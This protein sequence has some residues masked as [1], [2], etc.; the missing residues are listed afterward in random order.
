MYKVLKFKKCIPK[1]VKTLMFL[2]FG[3]ETPSGF[4]LSRADKPSRTSLLRYMAFT[5]FPKLQPHEYT[6]MRNTSLNNQGPFYV[7]TD[8]NQEQGLVFVDRSPH[9]SDKYQEFTDPT[10][11][12]I[13][14]VVQHFCRMQK[15]PVKREAETPH[16][17]RRKEAQ[18]PGLANLPKEIKEE[19]AYQFMDPEDIAS[20]RKTNPEIRKEIDPDAYLQYRLKH[21]DPQSKS[22]LI[23]II[24]AATEVQSLSLDQI[25]KL[26][27]I[28]EKFSEEEK[29][30]LTPLDFQ[31]TWISH[32]RT[33]YSDEERCEH[34]A[35]L[36]LQLYVTFGIHE[37]RAKLQAGLSGPLE[38][39][40][41]SLV[42]TE[43][44][45]LEKN[46]EGNSE[47]LGAVV[48]FMTLNISTV[49]IYFFLSDLREKI[50]L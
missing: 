11:I 25:K 31:P 38:K 28:F 21:Y 41:V 16:P 2:C 12:Q 22:S 6:D 45:M 37:E 39:R 19:M 50:T 1:N 36:L 32:L 43:A 44:N 5:L 3:K 15:P 49:H 9:V 30:N 33:D 7:V 40:L 34:L 13:A 20:L 14:E 8:Q 27:T 26:I 23:E 35:Y 24:Q 4:I 48:D 29:E 10:H 47:S 17:K 46:T 42:K 18:T